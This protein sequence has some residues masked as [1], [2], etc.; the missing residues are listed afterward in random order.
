MTKRLPLSAIATALILAAPT[1]W[2]A[3]FQVSEHSASG[4]GRAYAGEAAIADNASVIG[5][6]P[7]QM[8]MFKEKQISGALHIVNPEIDVTDNTSG[9]TASDVAPMQFVPATYYVNPVDDKWA[10]GVSLYTVYG[11]ATDY[12]D[13]FEAGDVAGDTSLTSV[14][15]N[16]SV[17]YRINEQ[18]SVGAGV[19]VVY[20][21]AKLNRHAG[22]LYPFF[23]GNSEG[24]K[25]I[26]MEGNTWGHGWNVGVLLEMD[27]NNRIGIAY[28]SEVKLDFAGDFTDHKGSITEL[29]AISFPV[30]C[31]FLCLRLLKCLATTKSR[32]IGPFITA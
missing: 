25:L 7:A 17:A 3:G 4:L 24:D 26:S 27:A 32:M 15:L 10:W 30:I 11:V 31:P 2:S 21:I 19:N 12:P 23:N 18:W 28:R 16:P 22:G 8:T 5:R 29:L 1:A 9:Q 14:N 13:A 20:A 6:N